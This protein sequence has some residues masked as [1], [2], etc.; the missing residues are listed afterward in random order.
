ML[1]TL[2]LLPVLVGVVAGFSL[3][4]RDPSRAIRKEDALL[5][6]DAIDAFEEALPENDRDLAC[7]VPTADIPL[8]LVQ[9]EPASSSFNSDMEDPAEAMEA[10]VGRCSVFELVVDFVFLP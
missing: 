7:K 2:A 1:A 9:T 6:V 4:N 3:P 10:V 5:P 8:V